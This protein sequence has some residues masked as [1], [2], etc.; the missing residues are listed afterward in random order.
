M[1]DVVPFLD[2]EP[3]PRVVRALADLMVVAFALALALS[4]LIRLPVTVSGRFT[5]VPVRGADPL[6]A[7]RAGIVSLVAAGEG[8]LVDEGAPLFRLRSELAGDR[9]GE[10]ATLGITLRGAEQRRDNERARARSQAAADRDE[11]DGLRRRGASLAREIGLA[12][13]KAE[14]A[15]QVVEHART[16]HREGLVAYDEVQTKELGAAQAELD[17]V[18]LRSEREQAA[19]AAERLGHEMEGKARALDEL[20]RALAEEASRARVRLETLRAAPAAADGNELRLDAPCAGTVVRLHARAPGAVVAEGEPLAELSCAG[21]ELRAEI[22][23]ADRGMGLIT[24]GQRAKL[25]YDAFPYQRHG[26][27]F[28][29]V[30]WIGPAA[31]A[32]ADAPAF[33]VQ[34][35]LAEQDVRAGGARRELRAGM[36]GDAEIIVAEQSALAYALEPLR[37]VRANLATASPP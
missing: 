14:L 1:R 36:T 28:A 10:V 23:V 7:P 11:L 13:R 4:V 3:P 21:E 30:R 34:A 27:R 12:E 29:T 26:V 17:L 18:R 31:V 37:A 2:P 19:V 8:A 32:R 35:N 5:L 25:F 16:A 20:E 6:R 33:R 22:A 15:A 9:A 24:A